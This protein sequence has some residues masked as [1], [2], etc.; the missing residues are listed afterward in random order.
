MICISSGDV[1]TWEDLEIRT[2]I[3]EMLAD[4]TFWEDV[5][6]EILRDREQ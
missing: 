4:P 6:E 3:W 5:L 1:P 2:A